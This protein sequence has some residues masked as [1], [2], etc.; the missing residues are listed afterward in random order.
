MSKEKDN[1]KYAIDQIG[2]YFFIDPSTKNI[3]GEEIDNFNLH[4]QTLSYL[5]DKN[6]MILGEPG[7]GKTTSAKVLSS[8]L[9]GYPFD[10]YET[11]QIQGHPEQTVEKWMARPDYGSLFDKQ[12]KVIWQMAAYFPTIIV[13]ELNR[14]PAG[15]QDELLNPIETGR[16]TYMNDSIFTGKKPFYA[17]A[18][19]PDDGNHIIIPPL[20]DRF[21]ICL[22]TGHIGAI[23]RSKIGDCKDNISREL[24]NYD[25]SKD[26]ID[27][28]NNKSISYQ[29]QLKRIDDLRKN[30]K[31][32]IEDIL[33]ENQK[34]K[35]LNQEERAK[36]KEDI[37][38][39]PMSNESE[40]FLQTIDSELNN[41]KTY[42]GKRSNDPIDDSNHA[43]N[44]A[45][46]RVMS[47]GSPRA[48]MAIE[49]FSKGLSYLLGEEEV[50]KGVVQAITPY[51]THHRLN[52]TED[53]RSEHQTKSRN[54]MF[55]LYLARDLVG[56]IDENYRNSV[57]PNL[58]L[59]LTANK[60]PE[61]LNK[62]HKKQ[63][64]DLINNIDKIDH[65]LIKEYALKFKELN[66]E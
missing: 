48:L 35:V 47:A 62:N 40:I 66:G 49:D 17:T 11:A 46:T 58:D 64:E 41:T 1:I 39:M 27:V 18:N 14:L 65:P 50:S 30:Y 23:N 7:F 57:V 26:I 52:F 5:L 22:E 15:K 38:S 45:S 34:F 51:A 29:D 24:V 10:V 12:E 44:L 6:S 25:L 3:N 61:K 2:E 37:R 21:D 32:H 55:T 28:I 33:S 56:K 60:N 31:S 19:H 43:K 9:S 53:Y 42:G 63:L 20:A 4:L 36:I 59:I 54:E 13:D 8:T 16:F